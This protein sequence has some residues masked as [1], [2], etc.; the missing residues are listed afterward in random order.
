MDKQA[1]TQKLRQ[2]FA[3]QEEVLLAFLFGSWDKNRTLSESDVDVAIWLRDPYTK[4]EM[5]RIWRDLESLLQIPVDLLLLNQASPTIAWTALRG[6]PLLIRDQG[7]YLEYML[8]TSR[9][10]EDFQ[11]FL[12]D[13]WQWRKRIRKQRSYSSGHPG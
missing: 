3:L 11:D 4:E 1:I 8:E 6:T 12:F 9:E 13:L 7:F 10:A 2:Y 5:N